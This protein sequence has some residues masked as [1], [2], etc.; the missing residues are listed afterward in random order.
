MKY[1][2]IFLASA[3]FFFHCSKSAGPRDI[4]GTWEEA[5]SDCDKDGRCRTPVKESHEF[6]FTEDTWLYI[7]NIKFKY[8][9]ITGH[10]VFS[11]D[12]NH[13]IFNVDADKI[14]LMENPFYTVNKILFLNDRVLLIQT[15]SRSDTGYYRYSRIK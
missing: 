12:Y 10:L 11:R 15:D 8:R 2:S 6:I 14:V 7:D 4:I 3:L 1:L 13:N 5:G 9:I